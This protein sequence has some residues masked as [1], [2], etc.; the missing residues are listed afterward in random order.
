MDNITSKERDLAVDLES[1]EITS[2]EDTSKDLISGNRQAKNLLTRVVSGLLG[3]KG[4]V[5]GQS[6]VN[7]CSNLGKFSE[8]AVENVELL[9]DKN[10]VEEDSG[11]HVAIMDK[12]RVKEK[13]KKTNYKKAPKPPR[14]PKGPSLDAADLKLVKEISELAMKKRARIERMKALKNM[15]AS[16]SSSNSS[17]PAMVITLLFCL[18]ILFQGLCSRS[19]SSESFHGSPEPAVVTQDLISVQFYNNLSTSDSTGH[20]SESPNSVEQASG[21][22]SRSPVWIGQN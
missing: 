11:E 10:L 19:S 3:F 4:L 15:K 1:G 6:G 9:P 16:S 17:V 5:G 12:N 7:S 8:V 20:S 21:S 18:V 14:P 2:E 13:R 22:E